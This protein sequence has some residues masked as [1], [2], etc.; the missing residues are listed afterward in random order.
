MLLSFSC[1]YYMGRLVAFSRRQW[2]IRGGLVS[3]GKLRG[4]SCRSIRT[5]Q[6][7]RDSGELTF[8]QWGATR[9]NSVRSN[10]HEFSQTVNLFE[11]QHDAAAALR[12]TLKV[13]NGGR[14]PAD[15]ELSPIRLTEPIVQGS[16]F[17]AELHG[18][19]FDRDKCA[20]T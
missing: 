6:G 10:A 3:F 18:R 20:P 11:F 14:L 1:R 8:S 2:Q 5:P 16:R 17:D 15:D 13:A 7:H 9:G 12:T 19:F 4:F